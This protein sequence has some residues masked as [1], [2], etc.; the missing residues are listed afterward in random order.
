MS[1]VA[2]R[3]ADVVTRTLKIDRGRITDDSRFIEDLGA[4]YIQSVELIPAFEEARSEGR[5]R[6]LERKTVRGHERDHVSTAS[7]YLARYSDMTT[8]DFFDGDA[9]RVDQALSNKREL[10][11]YYASLAESEYPQMD[12]I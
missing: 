10:E 12:L 5:L 8:S 4:E 3:V 9:L 7:E 2:Q 11:A 6:E 1:D